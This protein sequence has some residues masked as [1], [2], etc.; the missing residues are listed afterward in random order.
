LSKPGFKARARIRQV[1]YELN[2][3]RQL[4]ARQ[5]KAIEILTLELTRVIEHHTG[6]ESQIIMVLDAQGAPT[7]IDYAT[8]PDLYKEEE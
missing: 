7:A 4:S 3:F 5:D 6:T 1:Q 8:N 2:Q